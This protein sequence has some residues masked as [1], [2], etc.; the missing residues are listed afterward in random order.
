[1]KLC[2]SLANIIISK[3]AFCV[4]VI[5]NTKNFTLEFHIENDQMHALSQTQKH[6]KCC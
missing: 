5:L 4:I 2:L 1:M 6:L 3:E